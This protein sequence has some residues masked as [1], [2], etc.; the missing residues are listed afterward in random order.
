M[1][2]RDLPLQPSL[3]HLKNEAKQL[4]TDLLAGAAT[5][6]DRM[7]ANLPRLSAD[8]DVDDVSLMEAQHVLAREYGFR[9]WPHLAAAAEFD[10]DC[11]AYLS[12]KDTSRLVQEVGYRVFVISLKCAD[13]D[14]KQRLPAGMHRTGRAHV[15]EEL[16]IIGPIS[17]EEAQQA[18]RYILHQV[19]LLGRDGDI[20]WP[21]ATDTLP[22]RPSLEP[23]V[24]PESA[25]VLGRSLNELSLDEIRT[26]V[27][28]LSAQASEHGLQ[29]LETAAKLTPDA[30]VNEGLR[31]AADGTE[32][33]LIEDILLD[34]TRILM[35]IFDNR[36]CMTIEACCQIRDGTNPRV[37]E[38]KLIAMHYPPGEP[39][40][41][42]WESH[43][44]VEKLR[45]RLRGKS[46][47]AMDLDRL[48]KFYLDIAMIAR[49]QGRAAVA[50]ILED[51]DDDFVCAGLRQVADGVEQGDIIDD[52]HSRM[53]PALRAYGG[54]RR[55]FTAGLKAVAAAKKDADLNAC[56][57]EDTK[58]ASWLHNASDRMQEIWRR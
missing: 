51:V 54:R 39:L 7:R 11:L 44:T 23:E 28:G 49:G 3:R 13:D 9:E 2:V 31:I 22:P 38:H 52:L 47:A 19:R 41:W 6:A 43:G 58:P 57:A 45:G 21:P 42:N 10:F 32:P 5:A 34:R 30:F 15:M 35:Q 53:V 50:E 14:A 25:T 1:S 36:L 8:A 24:V 18:Q 33:D 37:L 56:L 20:T 46:V 40:G 48:A 12:K 26:L 27:R 4:H 29:S 16:E 55:L 17:E